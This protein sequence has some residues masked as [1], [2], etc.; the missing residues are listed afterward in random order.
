MGHYIQVEKDV[1]IYAEDIGSGQPVVFL[2]GW[3]LN[4]K[5]FEAQV[6]ELA[7][8][9]FRF[10]GIDLRGYGKSDK[11]WSGYDYDTAASDV[12]AV[13]D[14]LGL[15]NFVLAG[16]SMGGPIAIRYITKYGQQNINK[17][18]LLAAAAPLFTQ[19]EDFKINL[20][21]EEVDDIIKQLKED[22]PA[23]LADFADMF[24]EQKKSPEFIHWFQ[25]LGLE[26][27]AH[28]TI[29]SAIALRDEDLRGEL[30]GITVP[31]AIFHGKKDEICSYELGELLEKEIPNSVL[32]PFDY[33]GHGMNGDEPE[34]FNTEMIRFL[35]STGVKSE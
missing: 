5:A 27:G 16:F 24:F 11:P 10:I 34:R 15:E 8:N 2:H 30:A 31:T 26:A 22:R 13:V 7:L 18:W 25:L 9:G 20:K 4:S 35:K 32:V 29:N 23:F 3:P 17:L 19:R 21:T 14:H 1:K 33:S 12:K 6:S 28:S